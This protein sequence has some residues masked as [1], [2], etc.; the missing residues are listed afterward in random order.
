[1]SPLLILVAAIPSAL[2]ACPA[3]AAQLRADLDLAYSAYAS[4]DMEAFMARAAVVPEE[5]LCLSEVADAHLAA[6]LHLVIGLQAWV[7]KDAQA[8]LAAFR[9]LRAARPDFVLSPDVAPEGSRVRSVFDAAGE[10]YTAEPRAA[11]PGAEAWLVV[12][13]REA[14]RGV[15][16]GRTALVQARSDTGAARTWY[17]SGA[18]LPDDLL[19]AIDA[20][21]PVAS[22]REPA[23]SPSTA[24]A[25]KSKRGH[26]SRTL[27]ISGLAVAA[28]SGA[29]IAAAA[30]TQ[31]S[32]WA[33]ADESEANAYYAQNQVFG[34]G[35][36]ALGAAAVGLGATAVIVGR[37]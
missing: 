11:A 32:F 27:L 4:F 30:A 20:N 21:T 16:T 15:P 28:A 14:Q 9:G 37:W 6:Q 1:M 18:A 26:P 22:A 10:P 12:D 33:T 23:V 8:M 25:T 5:T 2:A 34:Y 3:S 24:A 29:A 19:A 7:A 13:G 36:Y 31:E 17:V 35:G